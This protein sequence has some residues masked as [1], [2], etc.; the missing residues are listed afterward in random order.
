MRKVNSY[1]YK[2]YFKNGCTYIGKHAELKRNDGYITS[3]S[4]YKKHKDLLEKREILIDN[5][6]DI[7][8]LDIMESLC[9]M[10]DICENPYNVNYNRGAW[11]NN[12]K[13]DRGFRGPANGMWGKH[14]SSETKL[15]MSKSWT[16]ERRKR[17]H[18]KCAGK[19]RPDNIEM[20]KL[21]EHIEKVK[22][23]RERW[24][25][26]H[27]F[28]SIYDDSIIV[29]YDIWKTEPY[30]SGIFKKEL[31]NNQVLTSLEDYNK[32]KEAHNWN[33][34]HGQRHYKM[35]KAPTK[36]K[37]WFNNGII[38]INAEECPEGYIKGRLPISKECRA[39]KSAEMLRRY[40]NGWVHPLKGKTPWNKGKPMSDKQKQ[41]MYKRILDVETGIIYESVN[42]LLEIKGISKCKYY[43]DKAN[44]K[45]KSAGK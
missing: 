20:N 11:L 2:L 26:K 42:S 43:R 32:W 36:G 44:G 40:N 45:Y 19:K 23:G 21:P 38:E 37:H 16:E 17:F 41:K 27:C 22:L 14:F 35:G 29:D 15:K 13:F 3:S 4:Y 25:R 31:Y 18:A 12:S 33:A 30:R 7:D 28:R 8:T 34:K 6:P 5:L 39:N 1:I 9:I 24:M 10:A